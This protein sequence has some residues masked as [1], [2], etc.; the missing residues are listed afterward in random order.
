MTQDNNV[1]MQDKKK[2]NQLAFAASLSGSAFMF[3]ISGLSVLTVKAF[4]G[5]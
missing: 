1:Q 5:D 4:R 3:C 2:K